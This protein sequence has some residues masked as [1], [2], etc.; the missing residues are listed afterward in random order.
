MNSD[1]S[2]YDDWS[3]SHRTVFQAFTDC[4]PSGNQ[5][6]DLYRS[7]LAGGRHYRDGVPPREEIYDRFAEAVLARLGDD[8]PALL[9]DYL[10]NPGA[11]QVPLLTKG[12]WTAMNVVATVLAGV[13]VDRNPGAASAQAL[14][15]RL[16][17]MFDDPLGAMEV[18]AHMFVRYSG[19]YQYYFFPKAH[20]CM[21]ML[22]RHLDCEG[23]DEFLYATYRGDYVRMEMDLKPPR[24]AAE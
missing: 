12:D 4:L 11:H 20:H 19:F 13:Y 3:E 21:R 17:R 2:F 8:A 23:V 24:K 1:L 22:L 7:V 5:L 15:A 18:P 6:G 16:R 10:V 14:M 9:L